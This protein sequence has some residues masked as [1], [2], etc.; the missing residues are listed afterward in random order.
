[1]ICPASIGLDRL[2]SLA[3]SFH[4]SCSE[5][6]EPPV[7]T[8]NGPSEPPVLACHAVLRDLYAVLSSRRVI[9]G[10]YTT[11]SDLTT[12]CSFPLGGKITLCGLV[13][14]SCLGPKSNWPSSL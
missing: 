14:K 2:T 8:L 13:S 10:L 4:T 6:P 1:M 7:P 12:Y 9:L 11:M 3:P 5:T